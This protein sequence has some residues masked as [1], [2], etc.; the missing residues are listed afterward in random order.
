MEKFASDRPKS[1]QIQAI[2]PTKDCWPIKK[3]LK[4]TTLRQK[5]IMGISLLKL[6]LSNN[7]PKTILESALKIPL[8]PPVM[9]TSCEYYL[10]REIH[11]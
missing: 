5:L 11:K 1:S 6:I 7:A 10:R 2:I 4:R 3:M 9:D 8:R